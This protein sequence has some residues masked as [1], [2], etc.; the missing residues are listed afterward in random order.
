MK[1]AESNDILLN[2]IE[3]E[4]IDYRSVDSVL[5]IDNAVQTLTKE[6]KKERERE[7][8]RERETDRQT[9]GQSRAVASR[10]PRCTQKP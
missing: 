5:E 10:Y 1:S 7:R 3:G 8:E 6:S 9:D 4:N 2:L